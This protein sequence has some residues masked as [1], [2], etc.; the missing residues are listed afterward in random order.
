MMRDNHCAVDLEGPLA[1][2]PLVTVPLAIPSTEIP[3]SLKRSHE[4]WLSFWCL[5]FEKTHNGKKLLWF[6]FCFEIDVCFINHSNISMHL[7]NSLPEMRQAQDL[8]HV[9]AVRDERWCSWPCGPR[10]CGTMLGT[11]D[12]LL[13]PCFTEGE[14][15]S[16]SGV[17]RGYIGSKEQ[18]RGLN[19]FLDT[20]LG[21]SQVSVVVGGGVGCDTL[22]RVTASTLHSDFGRALYHTGTLPG[23]SC[24]TLAAS[25]ELAIGL[26]KPR[27]RSPFGALGTQGI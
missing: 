26:G 4:Q 1:T 14:T 7:K 19:P 11:M 24:S 5:L 12:P 15:E 18:S 20:P 2:V 23:A 3:A 6:H 25:C 13:H 27:F 10:T 8:F 9:T 17:L 22:P 21:S 16:W